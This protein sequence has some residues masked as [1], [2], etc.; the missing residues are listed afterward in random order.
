MTV[1]LNLTVWVWKNIS[2]HVVCSMEKENLP[3]VTSCD[4][5]TLKV[6]DLI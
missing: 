4:P 2:A 1:V 5:P 3:K 6:M